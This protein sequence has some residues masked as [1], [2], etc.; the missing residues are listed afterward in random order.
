M[1]RAVRATFATLLA[2]A[3]LAA[4]PAPAEEGGTGH[5]TPGST[6]T[7]IDALPGRPGLSVANAF[8]YSPATASFQV[9]VAGVI[10][11]SLDGTTFADAITATYR[12]SFALL[13][14]EYA[15]GAIVPVGWIDVDATLAGGGTTSGTASGLGDAVLYPFMLGWIAPHDVRLE[16]RLGVYA[17]IG[18]YDAGSIANVS[19]NY[20]TFEPA[21]GVS[22]LDG[23]SGLEASG[24][25][26]I[27]F[28]TKNTATDYLTG[29]QLHADATMAKHF[30]LFGGTSG[31]G[32]S[33]FWY[34]QVTADTGSGARL[35]DF[36][37]RAMGA[38]PVVSYATNIGGLDTT[39]ELKWLPKF[40]VK[41]RVEG[42]ALWF[43]VRA[44]F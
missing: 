4:L 29:I 23:G 14:G 17:P 34:Q 3:V 42:N 18:R 38:G 9:P 19:K 36:K 43:K 20:W 27:D 5:Y 41:N 35:G 10:T 44:A 12:T 37:G 26:G 24:F 7:A 16:A 31:L 40:H 8:R 39:F 6:A 2:S 1:R 30:A 15:F 25:A 22:Y 28:N 11:S 13:G 32:V 21:F 33:G